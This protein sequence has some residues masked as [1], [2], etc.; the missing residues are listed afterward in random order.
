MDLEKEVV[1]KKYKRAAKRKKWLVKL[2]TPDKFS[3]IPRLESSPLLSPHF[4]PAF[5]PALV[6]TPVPALGP[7]LLLSPLPALMPASMLT[8]VSRL[9]SL[10]VLS[11]RHT[12][13]SCRK[14][15]ALLLPL[16]SMLGLSLSLG[17]SP[18]KTFK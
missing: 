8:L 17:F 3:F 6:S 9:G 12:S 2:Y 11:S 15:L 1:K 18:F 14:I 10:S 13:V 5:M 16:P 4:V 7:A